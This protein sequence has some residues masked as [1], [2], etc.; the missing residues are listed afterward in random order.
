MLECLASIVIALGSGFQEFAAPV[1]QRDLRVLE[2][3]LVQHTTAAQE[4]RD[5]P[6][7][8]LLVCSLDLIGGLL[9]GLQSSMLELVSQSNLVALTVQCLNVCCFDLQCLIN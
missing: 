6:D 7:T 1:F 8:E 2:L 3:T 9:E 4:K 5:Y